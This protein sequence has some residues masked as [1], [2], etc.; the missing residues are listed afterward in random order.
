MFRIR[1]MI[2]ELPSE[3]EGAQQEEPKTEGVV[4]TAVEHTTTS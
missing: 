1:K 4:S 3:A 2:V